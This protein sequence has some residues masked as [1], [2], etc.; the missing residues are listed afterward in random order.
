M[1][2]NP[3]LFPAP[4]FVRRHLL[5]RWR[6]ITSALTPHGLG[7]QLATVGDESLIPFEETTLIFGDLGFE[8]P[9]STACL[10]GQLERGEPEFD[11][12]H[13]DLH[14]FVQRFQT[15]PIDW[16]SRFCLLQRLSL[17]D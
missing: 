16:R 6:E 10:L 5:A 2:R 17:W 4:W 9:R 12:N 7:W 15:G 8:L 1:R 3:D 11:V 13:E 14:E